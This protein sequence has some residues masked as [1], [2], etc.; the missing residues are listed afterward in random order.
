[1][2]L[3]T[4]EALANATTPGPWNWHYSN[5]SIIVDGP[6]SDKVATIH[7]GIDN[8]PAEHKARF[9]AAANPETILAMIAL[10]REMGEA[11]EAWTTLDLDE[12]Q[13]DVVLRKYKEMTK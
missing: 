1:M 13:C 5:G 7:V 10:L 4:L 2:N 3:D 11:L 8:Q 12:Q 6:E 9:I